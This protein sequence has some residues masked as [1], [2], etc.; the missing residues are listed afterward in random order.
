MPNAGRKTLAH[1]GGCKI[2]MGRSGSARYGAAMSIRIIAALFALTAPVAG[3]ASAPPPA[4]AQATAPATSPAPV[5]DLVPVALDTSMGR[6]VIT[7]DRGRAPKTVA[8]FLAYIDGGKFD[9][10]TIYRAM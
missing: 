4:T 6:I 9:G 3:T 1:G 2:G 7:L 5:E 10:E 8:N